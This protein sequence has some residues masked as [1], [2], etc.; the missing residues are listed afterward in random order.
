[1]HQTVREFLLRYNTPAM[2]QESRNNYDDAYVRVAIIWL[3]YL[4]RYAAGRVQVIYQIFREFFNEPTA[5]SK[6]RM[7]YGDS[8]IRISIICFRYLILCAANT[9]LENTFPSVDDNWKSE[10]FKAY[11]DYLNKR[12]FISYALNHLTQHIRECKQ[13]INLETFVTL[14]SK[15][16]SNNP[17]SLLLENWIESHLHVNIAASEKRLAAECFRIN[18]LHTATGMKYSQVVEAV[19]ATGVN[20]EAY[21]GGKTPLLLSAETGDI[22][23]AEVLLREGARIDAQDYEKQ[24][25]LR[26]VAKKGHDTMV[27][28]LANNGANKDEVDENRRTALHHA[29]WN[30]HDSTVQ[31]LVEVLGVDMEATDKIGSTSM[32]YAAG[33]GHNNTLKQLVNIGA[34]INAEDSAKRT[35]LHWATIFGH[36]GTIQLLVN[37]LGVNKN[38]KDDGKHTALHYAALLGRESTVRLMVK[39]LDINKDAKNREGK[40]ALGITQQW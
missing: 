35:A 11:A 30:G 14:L 13:L 38:A 8:H 6:F 39:T 18:L 12:P 21:L 36:E 40:T 2:E 33:G 25:A 29:A 5:R 17:A 27:T 26:L 1:M 37:E 10:H 34:K 22:A 15:K 20:K 4:M 23:T 3:C 9:S 31:R 24:T 19:L 28:L 32:H 16:L 7:S